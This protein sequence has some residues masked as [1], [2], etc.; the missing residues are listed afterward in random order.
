MEYLDRVNIAYQNIKGCAAVVDKD[1]SLEALAELKKYYDEVVPRDEGE[2]LIN[3]MV[4]TLYFGQRRGKNT[5][6]KSSQPQ[7]S[8]DLFIQL[9][10]QGQR[11]RD[12]IN[13]R[14]IILITEA[15]RVVEE[16]K[17]RDHIHITWD[18]Q[19]KE[20]MIRARGPNRR[21]QRNSSTNK[22]YKARESNFKEKINTINDIADAVVD[23][24]TPKKTYKDF[25]SG[26]KWSDII[27]EK[28]DD[29]TPVRKT[30]EEF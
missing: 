6:R 3:Q 1:T 16:F 8:R 24:S 5:R 26:Q 11:K 21:P 29:Y 28:V 17:I 13:F 30:D 2:E 7:D 20:Y 4:K 27:S 14:C 25:V 12:P 23:E 18:D 15:L 19:S 22:N 9:L 10:P